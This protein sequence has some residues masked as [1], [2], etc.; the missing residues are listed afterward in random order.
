[1]SST[2]A[3]RTRPGYHHGDLEQALVGEALQTVR[4]RGADDVS[5]RRIA[6]NLGVSPSAAYAHFPD[7]NSLM[8]AVAH[9]GLEHLDARMD[10]VGTVTSQMSD[11]D[12][13]RHFNRIGAAYVQFAVD[14]AH[15][16]R[17]IF[18]P[19]GTNGDHGVDHIKSESASYRAL[20]N[21]LDELDRRGLMRARARAGLDLVAW[22]AMHG[23]ASLLLDEHLPADAGQVVLE[24]LA[25]L[26]LT[27][28]A[29]AH[30]TVNPEN[31]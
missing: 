20:C 23:F 27:D 29:A 3:S 15:L 11:P 8:V 18:G 28:E 16:F 4:R 30:I 13:V 2:S 31:Q 9:R 14:E 26:T 17:H 1:M 24:S 19:C 12:V 22:T 7:K 6:Q 5:L 25:R 10:A 21:V